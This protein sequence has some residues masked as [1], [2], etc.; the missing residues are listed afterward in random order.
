MLEY[1]LSNLEETSDQRK[2]CTSGS[3]SIYS[4]FFLHIKSA[5]EVRY[6][7]QEF[8]RQLFSGEKLGLKQS[9]IKSLKIPSYPELSVKTL[10]PMVCN[11]SSSG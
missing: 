2:I 1:L 8:L 3:L 5:K 11:F 6:A 4:M 7:N 9:Q 10:F